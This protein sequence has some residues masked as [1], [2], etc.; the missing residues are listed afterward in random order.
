MN[1]PEATTLAELTGRF[2]DAPLNRSENGL[3]G[4]MFVDVS[5]AGNGDPLTV[6]DSGLGPEAYEFLDKAGL[7]PGD[8]IPGLVGGEGDE[9][10]QNARTPANVQV[11]FRS[12]TR[13]KLRPGRVYATTFFITPSGAGVFASGT[14]LFS[15][16]L[17][18][19]MGSAWDP[20]V[21]RLTAAV[22]DWM[23][24]H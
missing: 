1:N 16:G 10:V 21:E 4:V 12:P 7:R 19:V 9:L 15:N 11:L 22:L 6:A 2:R 5:D 14:N 23:L 3:Y 8:K 17:D 20:R 24:R 18:P 13:F